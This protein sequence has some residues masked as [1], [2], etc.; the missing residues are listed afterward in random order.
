[1]SGGVER[2]PAWAIIVHGGAKEIVPEQEEVNR[3]GCLTALAA[4]RAL[5]ERD[6]TAVAAVEA[7]IR[8]LEDDPTFNAGYGSVLNAADEVEMDAAVMDGRTLDVGAVAGI[9]GVRHP[10]SVAGLLLG[11]GPTLLVSDGARTFA[12]E[13]GA[14]LCDPAAMITPAQTAC[15][16]RRGHDTVGCVALDSAGNLAAGTSTGGLQ[17]TPP[18]RVGDSPL[19]GCG[20]YADNA[21]GAVAFSGDGE[22]IART[23]LAARVMQGLEAGREPKD[24]VQRSLAHL[25]RVGG[26]AG[27]IAVDDQGRIGFA[28]NSSHFA[29]AWM[30]DGMNTP[31]VRLR[32]DEEV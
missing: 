25:G 19:P 14:E 26:E 23:L 5:L 31:R 20:F 29:L 10:V 18:G 15:E 3:A 1:M 7:A 4:G 30:S 27:G 32:Q 11:E 2:R 6:G 12:A 24:A 17:G 8:V 16:A 13:R 21:A 9:K 28:H 22:S